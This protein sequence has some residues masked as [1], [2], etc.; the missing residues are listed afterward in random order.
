MQRWDTRDRPRSEQY[1]YWREVV[2]AAFTPLRPAER[3]ARDDWSRAGLDGRVESRPFGAVN[4][5]E[6]ATVAQVIHHGPDEVRRVTDDVV[7]INL[8]LS[9]RCI[10][11][12]DGRRSLSGPGSFTIVDATRP[13]T[14]DYLDPWH[15][16]SFRIPAADIPDTVRTGATARGY[17][18]AGLGAVLADTLRSSWMQSSRMSESEADAA[19]LAVASLT[20]ALS[21]ST[22]TA[23]FAEQQGGDAVLRNSIQHHLER[24]IRF[25]DTSPAA[26]ARHFAISVRKL[27]QLYEGAPLTFG[28]TVMRVRVLACA[29]ELRAERGRVTMTHLAAKWGFSDLSHLHR[30]FRQHIGQ[31]PRDVLSSLDADSSTWDRTA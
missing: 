23:T 28:Q 17:A 27:H 8:M 6:I 2:C 7:F 14:L 11:T 12:Q 25:V 9:G 4:G 13:F 21:H 18:G 3:D 20:R 30:A 19:G 1:A 31:S 16:V 22:P 29:D 5:A 24:H 26:I 15:T 10:V